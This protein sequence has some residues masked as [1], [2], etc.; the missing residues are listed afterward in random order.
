MIFQVIP[1]GSLDVN[2][3]I[4]G[5]DRTKE[6]V[7]VD[8]GGDAELIIRKIK[9][10]GLKITD[11]VLTHG[12]NDHIGALDEVQRFTGATVRIH[13]AD[14]A[15]LTSSQLNLSAYMGRPFTCE[16]ADLLLRDGDRLQVGDLDLAIIHTPG[17]TRGG[18]CI[19][20]GQVLISGDTLFAGGVGRTDFPG[21]SHEVLVNSI[22]T[23]LFKLPDETEVYPGHG[24]ATTI[25]EEKRE[26]PYV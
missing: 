24:P 21:G 3:Y 10:L 12:H 8:P 14:A 2:C 26:N 9:G 18:I 15:M 20:T 11:I 23:K 25:G 7:V 13:Q 17:H 16:P 19:N 4:L 1:V 5:S 6:A 22:Q